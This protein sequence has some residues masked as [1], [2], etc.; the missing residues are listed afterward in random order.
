MR[1]PDQS[2]V[3]RHRSRR[4]SGNALLDLAFVLP[5]LLMLTFGAVEYGYALYVKHALQGAAREGARAAIVA[6]ATPAQVQASV[7]SA[8]QVA[9]FPQAKYTRPATITPTNW[10]SSAAGTAV[11]VEVKATW[12]TVGV[13][14]LPQVMG[15]INPAKQ[16]K[17]ATT[18]RKEG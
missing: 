14:V 16:L 4:R 12:S 9:G 5:I 17:S 2:I 6:G 11:T 15:G 3:R 10:V 18:M 1:Q 7:D 8:M 13:Q